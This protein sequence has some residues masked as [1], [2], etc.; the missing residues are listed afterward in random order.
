MQCRACGSGNVKSI[1]PLGRLPLANRLLKANELHLEEPKYNLEVML[2]ED[3]GLAQLK[4]LVDPKELFSEYVYFSSNSDL[5]LKSAADLVTSIIPDLKPDSFVVEIASNDGYLLKNYVEKGVKSLG[6]DPAKNIA[7]VANRKGIETLCAFFTENLAL[8]LAEKGKKAD[9]IHANNVM[10]HV[11]DINGFVKGIKYLLKDEGT[12][13]IEVPYLLDLVEKLEFDTIYHEHVYYF[14]VTPLQKLFQ[15][16]GL[17]IE[18]IDKIPL[19]GGTLRLTV[20]H[21]GKREC[22]KSVIE[23][24]EQEKTKNVLKFSYYEALIQ[25]LKVLQKKLVEVLHKIKD[26]GKSIAAYGASAKG[27]TLLNYFNI[28]SEFLDFVVDRSPAKQGYYT[29]GKKLPIFSPQELINRKP[30]YALLLTWNFCED[31]LC[32]QAEYRKGGGKFIVPIPEVRIV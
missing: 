4:D 3:C 19:H 10:A 27:T 11:P 14:S 5:M 26:E 20:K 21:V 7:E 30:D 15:R 24:I 18:N 22:Q 9:I 31:I 25:N 12:A 8:Q 1:I 23:F 2:C 6:I 13:I 29:P 28:G 16:H 32:Q 17:E